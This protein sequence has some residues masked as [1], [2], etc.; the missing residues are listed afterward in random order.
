MSPRRVRVSAYRQAKVRVQ[1]PDERGAFPIDK[2]VIDLWLANEAES[3][4]RA[5]H[6]LDVLAETVPPRTLETAVLLVSE[7]VTNAVLHAEMEQEEE[8]RLQA[9]SSAGT[10]RVE[11]HDG[12]PDFESGSARQPDSEEIGGWGLY[13]VQTLSDRWGIERGKLVAVW[14]E[15]DHTA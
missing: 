11:I 2:P 10:V 4:P 15:V 7:L 12:G 3:V 13:L 5:R 1:K 9:S 6:S 14:F 8:I